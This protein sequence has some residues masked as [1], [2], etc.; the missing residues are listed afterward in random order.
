VNTPWEGQK[1][2]VDAVKFREQM[3]GVFVACGCNLLNSSK[4]ENHLGPGAGLGFRSAREAGF[5]DRGAN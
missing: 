1:A 2:S 4:I 5:H 3:R